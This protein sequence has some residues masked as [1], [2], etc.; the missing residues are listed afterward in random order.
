MFYDCHFINTFPTCRGPCQSHLIE[1]IK[2][3]DLI[4]VNEVP[5]YDA[6]YDIIASAQ[7]ISHNKY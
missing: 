2:L 1:M 3:I 4:Q 6:I 7:E 5:D